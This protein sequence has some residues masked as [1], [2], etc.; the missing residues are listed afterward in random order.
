MAPRQIEP[1]GHRLKYLRVNWSQISTFKKIIFGRK[2]LGVETLRTRAKGK[3]SKQKIGENGKDGT[4]D[5][6]YGQSGQDEPDGQN[7]KIDKMDK[8]DNRVKFTKQK[9]G[10]DGQDD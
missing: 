1:W 9:I 10:Q 7:G 8:M 5:Q 2:H 6:K 4:D 3:C